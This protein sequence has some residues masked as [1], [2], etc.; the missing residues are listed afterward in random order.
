MYRRC[1][2]RCASSGLHS[3]PMLKCRFFWEAVGSGVFVHVFEV[4]RLPNRV[5]F[6]S[7]FFLN[8][9]NKPFCVSY[10]VRARRR[11]NPG[12]NW[13]CRRW[14]S[15]PCAS[16]GP[17]TVSNGVE[18][19]GDSGLSAL[20]RGCSRTRC[21]R[22]IPRTLRLS[23]SRFIATCFGLHGNRDI[24]GYC[25]YGTIFRILWGRPGDLNRYQ[26]FC[27]GRRRALV[28]DEQGAS[29]SLPAVT[30]T[31]SFAP[32][33]AVYFL[34]GKEAGQSLENPRQTAPSDYPEHLG[35]SW[36]FILPRR[37]ACG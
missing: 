7:G 27:E 28:E 11:V 16:I 23:R 29:Q 33:F 3:D 10:T 1:Q 34:A 19:A 25:A 18:K 35:A 4:I 36:S 20:A 6:G 8:T 32:G 37:L 12:W 31:G 26:S 15:R 13:D 22:R 5:F 14:A 17:A 30:T 24:P 21:S 2:C 9:P